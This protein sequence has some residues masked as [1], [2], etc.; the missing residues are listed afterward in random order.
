MN[1]KDIKAFETL[2]SLLTNVSMGLILKDLKNN[3]VRVNEHAAKV[4]NKKSEEI[5]GKS[6]EELFGEMGKNSL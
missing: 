2:I 5:E 3:I 1:E 4:I 6:C